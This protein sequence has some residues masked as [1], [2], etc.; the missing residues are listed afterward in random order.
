MATKQ[1]SATLLEVQDLHVYYGGIH[2]LK[3]LSFHV[4]KGE[5]VSLI[6][7]NGAG[8]TTTLRAVSGILPYKGDVRLHGSS[9]AGVPAH[10]IVKRHVAHSPEGRGVFANLTVMENLELGAYIRKDHAQIQKDLQHCF[11]LFP[12]LKERLQQKAGTLSG[13]EQQMLAMARALMTKP[14]LLMLDEPSLG[15][16]PLIVAQIF[17]I[18]KK[19]NKEGMTILLVEQNARMALEISH[20]AYVVE[21]GKITFDGTGKDLLNDSRVIDSYLGGP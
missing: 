9:L 2:A 11:E 21:T 18:V 19:V 7:A 17:E 15:L 6:G 12:R 1:E 8:K 10:E 5:I 20:R 13:G 4:D 14:E 3:G 16:A